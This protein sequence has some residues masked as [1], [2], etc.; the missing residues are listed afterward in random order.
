[1]K[2]ILYV[3]TVLILALGSGSAFAMKLFIKNQAGQT[4]IL[5][6]GPSYSIE[7]VKAMIQ[8]NS[9]IPVAAQRLVFAGKVLENTRTLSDYNVQKESTL[10]VIVSAAPN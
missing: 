6:V 9:G 5:D 1:M 8:M 4:L 2:K 7:K 3:L 10:H